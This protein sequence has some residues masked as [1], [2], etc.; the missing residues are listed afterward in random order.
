MDGR[1]LFKFECNKQTPS[2]LTIHLPEAD[3]AFR[4]QLNSYAGGV[5]DQA[6]QLKVTML[7][8]IFVVR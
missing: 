8:F 3:G 7:L 4:E 1:P 2:T 5:R 6:L